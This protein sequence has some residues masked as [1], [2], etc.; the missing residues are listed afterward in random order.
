MIPASSW[1]GGHGLRR[2]IDPNEEVD[3]EP[4][5]ITNVCPIVFI[6]TEFAIQEIDEDLLQIMPRIGGVGQVAVRMLLLVLDMRADPVQRPRHGGEWSLAARSTA[7]EFRHRCREFGPLPIPPPLPFLL[8]AFLCAPEVEH[9]LVM[10]SIPQLLDELP[11]LFIGEVVEP[12][13]ERLVLGRRFSLGRIGVNDVIDILLAES[14]VGFRVFL[15]MRL[16]LCKLVDA[17][18]GIGSTIDADVLVTP[19]TP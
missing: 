8:G 17:L 14:L 3:D 4:H 19:F 1:R 2:C 16:A 10:G 5:S 9:L 6:V 15:A 18:T 11:L 13:D 7:D 12:I